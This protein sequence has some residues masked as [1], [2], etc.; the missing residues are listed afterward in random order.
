MIVEVV[1][2]KRFLMNLNDGSLTYC[3]PASGSKSMLDLSVAD[4]SFIFRPHL[5]RRG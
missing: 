3:H 4:P 1:C 2:L 5:D